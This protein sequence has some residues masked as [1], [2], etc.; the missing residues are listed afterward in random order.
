[1]DKENGKNPVGNLGDRLTNVQ[2]LNMGPNRKGFMRIR[3]G[4][5]KR[6]DSKGS[7]DTAE[8]V[9]LQG[10]DQDGNSNAKAENRGI[11][12]HTVQPSNFETKK[13]SLFGNQKN[14][15]T[16]DTTAGKAGDSRSPEK[17]ASKKE[18]KARKKMM[19]HLRLQREYLQYLGHCLT[20]K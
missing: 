7:N 5:Q 17:I 19:D 6:G 18:R 16:I 15:R 1:M 12:A 13:N 2:V 20:M 9:Y 3:P 14:Q 11:K 10:G 4:F 8:E